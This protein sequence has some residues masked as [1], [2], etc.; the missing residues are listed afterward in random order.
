MDKWQ[1]WLGLA[2]IAFI[3]YDR[4]SGGFGWLFGRTSIEKDLKR[5]LD[6]LRADFTERKMW[7]DSEMVRL[8]GRASDRND[9]LQKMVGNMELHHLGLSKDIEGLR[10]DVDALTRMRRRES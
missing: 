4:L 10:R 7:W 8:H 9:E 5:E 6:T 3:I 1:G 2:G